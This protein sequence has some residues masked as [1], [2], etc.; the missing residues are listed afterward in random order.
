MLWAVDLEKGESDLGR[1]SWLRSS[2]ETLEQSGGGKGREKQADTAINCTP[3][4]L[5]S[6][7]GGT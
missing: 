7:S 3:Y 6:Q 5:E 2:L 1:S 4:M